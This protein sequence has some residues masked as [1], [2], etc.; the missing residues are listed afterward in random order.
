MRT[1]EALAKLTMDALLSFDAEQEA[2]QFLYG[3]DPWPSMM[4]Q[5]DALVVLFRRAH[6]AGRAAG[7]LEGANYVDSDAASGDTKETIAED[8]RERAQ[9]ALRSP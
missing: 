9:R 3:G 5:R 4:D 7:L 1:N 2:R 6:Q 8:L